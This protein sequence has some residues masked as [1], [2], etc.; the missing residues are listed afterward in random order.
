VRD[1][2]HVSDLAAAHVAALKRLQS[3]GSSL[4]LNLGTGIGHSVR[5]VVAMVEVFGGRV[6]VRMAARRA[7]DPPQLVAAAHRARDVLD[8]EPRHSSLDEIV[9]TA[10]HWHA[11]HR[12][13]VVRP[14]VPLVI[15]PA[16]SLLLGSRPV[17]V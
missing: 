14:T 16:P 4:A 10:W 17:T 9:S 12:N 5:D 15:S 11:H 8:W 3:G 13:R 1:Y 7:G 6:P 2:V